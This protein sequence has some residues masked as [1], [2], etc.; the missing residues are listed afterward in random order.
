MSPT[1]SPM[2]LH[3]NFLKQLELKFQLMEEMKEL[4][5]LAQV[6]NGSQSEC[7]GENSISHNI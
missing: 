7:Y 5:K 4:F 1:W 2:L 3:L 6:P